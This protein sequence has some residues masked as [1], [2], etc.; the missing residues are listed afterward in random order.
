MPAKENRWETLIEEAVELGKRGKTLAEIGARFGVS[1]Q[2]MKQ[3]FDQYHIDPSEIGCKVRTRRSREQEAKRYWR[4]W[5]DK[6]QVLYGEKRQKYR[7]KKAN[8]KRNGQYFELEFADIDWPTHCP[9]LGIELDYL[10][11][12]KQDNS[13][14][15]DRIFPDKGYTKDNIE[16][17][18]VRANRIKNDA[19]PEELQKLAEYYK[20]YL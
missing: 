6:D 10:S 11:E 3:V 14:S 16:I 17:V 7:A 8:A 9:V 1:R 5:G 12:G 19:S 4:K 18:S 2:R 13:V 20:K 15:F